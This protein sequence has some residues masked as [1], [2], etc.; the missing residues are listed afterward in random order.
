[1]CAL[2]TPETKGMPN[3]SGKC[4]K[5]APPRETLDVKAVAAPNRRQWHPEVE[6]L[7]NVTIVAIFVQAS[8]DVCRRHDHAE[9][10]RGL[11][12]GLDIDS[13]FLRAA[14][15]RK[16]DL[17]KKAPVEIQKAV[18]R[19]GVLPS[20]IEPILGFGAALLLWCQPHACQLHALSQGWAR[21]EVRRPL[22]LVQSAERHIFGTIQHCADNFH[23]IVPVRAIIQPDGLLVQWAPLSR[24]VPQHGLASLVAHNGRHPCSCG[25]SI[26]GSHY[27]SSGGFRL[28]PCL[29]AFWRKRRFQR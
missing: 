25:I 1:M 27:G 29:L 6:L 28:P 26:I 14:E 19:R 10:R 16:H 23:K 8:C 7:R 9:Y 13:A 18:V 12:R 21:L 11:H 2:V 22:H 15:S 3:L 17:S 20:T 5:V 24:H 4:L